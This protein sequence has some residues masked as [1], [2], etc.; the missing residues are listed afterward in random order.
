VKL[1]KAL[2]ILTAVLIIALVGCKKAEPT[3][4][5]DASMVDP[6][7]RPGQVLEG[8]NALLLG[9]LKL[10][11]TAEAITPAQ[12]AELLPLWQV[13]AGGSLQ[14]TAE[15]QAVADQ[16]EAKMTEAQLA[17]IEGMALSFEDIQAL[18]EEQGIEMPAPPEG[19]QQGGPGAF[20]DM[21]EEER[22]QLREQFQNM[23]QEERATRM[24]EMGVQRPEGGQGGQGF[25]RG[26]RPGGGVRGGNAL[27][28]PLIELLTARAA[29]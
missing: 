23:S 12:A 7:S 29:E 2:W 14:G 8:M 16:I 19:G 27:I 20:G 4:V 6:E 17:A 26:T 5:A 21:S 15:T 1:N 25:G 10:E 9:T 24:A 3:P 28:E 13:I 11:G 18:M 22:T